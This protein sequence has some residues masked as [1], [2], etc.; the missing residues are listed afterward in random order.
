MAMSNYIAVSDNYFAVS[1]NYFAVSDN[2]VFPPLTFKLSHCMAVSAHLILPALLTGRIVCVTFIA[3]SAQLILPAL[4][5]GNI[6]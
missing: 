4:L 2:H 5:T 1:D 6:L 3:V